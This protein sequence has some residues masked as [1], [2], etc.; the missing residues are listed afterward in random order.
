M[1]IRLRTIIV[2]NLYVVALAILLGWI[3]QDTAGR[4][5]EE[6]YVKE[7]VA[8]ASG[9]LKDKRFPR[10]DAM[11]GYLREL[12][13]A[14]WIS[15]ENKPENI[16]ASSL[17]AEVTSEF[18]RQVGALGKSGIVYLA[19]KKYRFDTADVDAGGYNTQ[20]IRGRLYM[21][22]PDEQFTEARKRTQRR[23]MFIIIPTVATAT[24]LAILFSISIT[25]PIR[26]LASQMDD[27]SDADVT[28]VHPLSSESI[29]KGPT[30]IRQLA[31]SFDQLL[32]RLG[33]ARRH[34]L[35][36]EQLATLGKISLSVAHELRNP[37]SGIKMNVR[38]LKDNESLRDDPG[39]AA[40]LREIDRMGLYL[41]E[42]M[43]LS[44]GNCS[45]DR[46]LA[47]S[48][49]CLSELADSVLVILAGKLRHA[50]IEVQTDFPA[51][52]PDVNVDAD[53]IRQAMMNLLVN[54]VEA[55]PAGSVIHLSIR[56]TGDGVRFSVRDAGAG[57]PVD[58]GDVFAA[59]ATS[60]PNGVGLGLYIC[61][62]IITRHGGRIGYD[63]SEPG[64]TFWF[65]IPIGGT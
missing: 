23:V 30:E 38:N 61:K 24:L 12:F 51:D 47:P 18:R 20:R 58:A 1:S 2:L 52:E 35:Q 14:E 37:L 32:H 9:F 42:L 46:I 60:K 22:V 45:E 5:V 7:M 36:S 54:A 41:D 33:E 28:T 16:I 3:A 10:D 11:M 25:R 15:S 65:E 17:P 44:P 34:V 59:F 13:N 26:K 57:V 64:A 31:N 50:K 27:V 63:N 21:L 43:N 49:A 56:Q 19:G 8:S 53:Q 55:S 48:P 29:H 40:I 4:L 39:I 62:Q 6:R